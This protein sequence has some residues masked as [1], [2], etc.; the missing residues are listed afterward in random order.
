M[1]K[2]SGAGNSDAAVVASRVIEQHGYEV[3][4]I[5]AGRDGIQKWAVNRPDPTTGTGYNPR[6]YFSRD[7]LVAL[8]QMES[9]QEMRAAIVAAEITRVSY[10]TIRG[11]N[12]MTKKTNKTKTGAAAE[13]AARE[14]RVAKSTKTVAAKA[15]KGTKAPAQKATKKQSANGNGKAS[16]NIDLSDPDVSFLAGFQEQTTTE[17]MTASNMVN[18]FKRI[19]AATLDN[20]VV[21]AEMNAYDKRQA[22]ELARL[23]LVQKDKIEGVGLGYFAK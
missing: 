10:I 14:A 11:E 21:N 2:Q 17:R 3:R 20:P 15:G 16:S 18:L 13:K 19:K 1:S 23:G 7:G 8:A 12:H 22:R 9:K 4:C 6:S 5:A